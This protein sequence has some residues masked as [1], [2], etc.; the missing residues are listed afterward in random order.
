MGLHKH[1]NTKQ[2]K[3][4]FH[5]FL[6]S[7][8]LFGFHLERLSKKLKENDIHYLRRAGKKLKAFYLFTGFLT[9]KY[10][11]AKLFKP[12]KAVYEAAGSFRELQVNRNTLQFYLPS[13]ELTEQYS[14]FL[15]QKSRQFEKELRLEIEKFRPAKGKKTINRVQL[16]CQSLRKYQL[17]QAV[18][19]Y[20]STHLAYV[21]LRIPKLYQNETI[22]HLRI[23]LKKINLVNHV[24]SAI[25][26][27]EFDKDLIS[28]IKKLEDKLGYWHDR[29]VLT[30]SLNK[31]VCTVELPVQTV[32][33]C[34]AIR[35]KIMEEDA[36]LKSELLSLLEP[37]LEKLK[38]SIS[39]L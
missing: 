36:V 35:Q 5:A 1:F 34:H 8:S 33:E 39:G 26:F 20:I 22:H 6:E 2:G 12:I 10:K 24:M 9:E 23:D 7:E 32:S 3:I 28:T 4:L 17:K 31:M 13:A 15:K 16:I 38:I 25:G 37:C 29:D 19:D 27:E 14:L 21:E 11:P 30:D 18:K